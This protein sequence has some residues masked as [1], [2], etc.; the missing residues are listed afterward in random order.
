MFKN[1][2]DFKNS[3]LYS[4]KYI[5][6]PWLSRTKISKVSF[7]NK[8]GKY[9]LVKENIYLRKLYNKYYGKQ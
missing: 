9:S 5:C 3:L 4:E 1:Y 2:K 6:I 7:I 8:D